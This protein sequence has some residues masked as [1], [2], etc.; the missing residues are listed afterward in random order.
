MELRRKNREKFREVFCLY[1][2]GLIKVDYVGKAIRNIPSSW[3]CLSKAK[4]V[5][6][7]GVLRHH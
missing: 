4:G 3:N 2:T 5:K 1:F 6:V 7:P